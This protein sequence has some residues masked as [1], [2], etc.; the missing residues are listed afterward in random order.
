MK[1]LEDIAEMIPSDE[2]VKDV[3][4]EEVSGVV[5]DLTGKLRYDLIP[6][7]HHEHIREMAKV[8]T[9]G[10]EFWKDFLFII[11]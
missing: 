1:S 4:D 8:L 5:Y 2:V 3:S 6:H 11:K 7:E 9:T 10:R